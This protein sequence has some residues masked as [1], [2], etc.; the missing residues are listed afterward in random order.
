MTQKTAAK[1]KQEVQHLVGDEY[2]VLEPYCGVKHKLK[3][4]HNQCGHV[5]CVRPDAFL[6]GSRCPMCA[7]KQRIQA[8][9]LTNTQFINRVKEKTYNRCTIIEPYINHR[10][11][12]KIQCNQCGYIWKILPNNLLSGEGCPRCNLEHQR[13]LRAKPDAFFR[14]EINELVG[15]EYTVLTKYKNEYTKIQVRHNICGTIYLATPQM[16]LQGYRCPYCRLRGTV[17]DNI[18]YTKK[19]GWRTPSTPYPKQ[20]RH[21]DQGD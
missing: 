12:I 15:D 9:T 8:N 18:I 11:K 17:W 21:T 5:W 2:S 19:E 20:Y 1:F 7:R 3:F 13:K 16:F 6:R 14:Q 10:T 4:R